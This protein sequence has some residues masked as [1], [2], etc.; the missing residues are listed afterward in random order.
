LI[1]F[2]K[3][4]SRVDDH[5]IQEL[6]GASAIRLLTAIQP[7]ASSPRKLRE[8]L[9][10]ARTPVD[11]LLARESRNILIDLLRPAEA[12]D[13]ATVVGLSS[14]RDP[15]RA[16]KAA[17]YSQTKLDLLL[18]WFGLRAPVEDEVDLP[19][20][21]TTVQVKSGLFPH[22]LTAALKVQAALSSGQRRVLLHMPTGSGKTRTAMQVIC[23]RLR[24]E[25]PGVVIWLA[26]SEELCEQAATEFQKAWT[27]VG[28]RELDLVRCWGQ[29]NPDLDGVR[30]GVI[31]GGLPK[32]YSLARRNVPLL[33]RLG[34]RT[35]LVVMDE[36]HQAIAPTYKLLLDTLVLPFPTN[37]LFG[38]SATPGRSW[39]DIDAD[40]QLAEFFGR[41][42]VTLTVPGYSNPV[43]Y[44]VNE[45]YLAHVR[46][47]PLVY[48][49][50]HA[51]APEDEERLQEAFDLPPELLD[52]LA[53]D[54]KRNLRII[55]ATESLLR[56]H[57][58]VMLF[59][60]T[61]EHSD[62][63][64]LI[65]QARGHQAYSITGSTPRYRRQ[66]LIDRYKA[67][68]D[69]P[70]VLCNFG[71]L[72]TGFDAPRT[73]AALIARPTKSLVLYSQMVGRASR[74]PRAGGNAEAEIVTVVDVELPGFREM[75][76]AFFNWEDVWS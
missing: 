57:S 38:L 64:A 43:D 51:L 44:L 72:T 24:G 33:G 29:F 19:A 40:E 76:E 11:L 70:M 31:I 61:V 22:Q 42:K 16:L 32:L 6:L 5:D 50:G 30:D 45:R 36:A 23:D 69:R 63:L 14:T 52:R 65:L 60:A 58:R 18:A 55:E 67:S 21:H 59:A 62:L 39:S 8:L 48:S 47:E 74:G 2:D 37:S 56:R 71:V 15:Y 34:A 9:L 75:A 35:R 13:L 1:E 17:T 73:S 68:D 4:F 41:K 66:Q 53:S 26:H 28:N 3:F 10:S 27:H 46:Y 49:G 7:S 20:A 12:T 54:E 25:P